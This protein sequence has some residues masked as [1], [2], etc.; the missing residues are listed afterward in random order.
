MA[1]DRVDIKV[2]AHDG[3]HT[4]HLYTLVA[5]N[6][7]QYQTLLKRLSGFAAILEGE[8]WRDA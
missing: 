3:E 1:E 6:S 2:T 7:R 8:N 4:M 5:H